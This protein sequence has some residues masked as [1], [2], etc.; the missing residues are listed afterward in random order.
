MKPNSKA[1]LIGGNGFIG[2]HL[3]D[4]L[5]AAGYCVRSLDCFP[6]RF[7]APLPDVEY[8][9]GSFT[10]RELVARAAAGCDVLVHLAHSTVPS[11]SLT[12]PEQ[13]ITDSIGAFVD[14]LNTLREKPI[15]VVYFSSG[16]AVYGNAQ[17]LPTPEDAPL[18]PVSP[19]GVAKL[20][21]EKYLQMFR[22]LYGTEYLIIRPSNPYG[23]RQ[24]FAGAQGVIPIFMNRI[25]QGIPLTVWGDGSAEKDYIYV[26]DL[27]KAVVAL[28]QSGFSNQPFNV[29]SGVGITLN[30]LISV[31]ES[32]VGKTV[33]VQYELGHRQD[34]SRMVLC[35]QR[36]E[37]QIGRKPRIELEAGLRLTAEWIRDQREFSK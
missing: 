17:T 9:I 30:K 33:D 34:V 3:T 32:V 15:K 37:G 24:N 1:L 27:A 21:M 5:L 35:G 6:E 10:D 4:E 8:M 26:S 23:P 19:Y 2:S 11:A 16:G 12:H 22:H 7:R 18:N 31:I 14:V 36:L 29:A 20:A 25:L 13:E 28:M